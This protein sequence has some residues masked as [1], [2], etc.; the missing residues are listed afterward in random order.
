MPWNVLIPPANQAEGFLMNKWT[1]ENRSC[2]YCQTGAAT[3]RITESITLKKI[4]IIKTVNNENN[5]TYLDWPTDIVRTFLLC[6]PEWRT[7][8]IEGRSRSS[9]RWQKEQSEFR[10]WEVLRPSISQRGNRGSRASET[11]L[12]W[13]STVTTSIQISGLTVQCAFLLDITFLKK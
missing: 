11:Y 7:D 1:W 4:I 5:P 3:A 6:G 12:W 2:H 10:S 9:Y 8:A 13:H